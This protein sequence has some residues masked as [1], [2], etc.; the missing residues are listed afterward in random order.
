MSRKIFGVRLGAVSSK[1][2][3]I[4][5]WF[6]A[7]SA[8]KVSFRKAAADCSCHWRET[9]ARPWASSANATALVRFADGN[10]LLWAAKML[11]DPA[12]LKEMLGK[13]CGVESPHTLEKGLT[14]TSITMLVFPL[15][16]SSFKAVLFPGVVLVWSLFQPGDAL[17]WDEAEKQC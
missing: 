10:Y 13:C 15:S 17:L 3:F 6:G 2:S 1:M 9:T 7:W 5:G 4:G 16:W 12:R 14:G 8:G 11:P